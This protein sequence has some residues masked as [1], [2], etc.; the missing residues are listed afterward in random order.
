MPTSILGQFE[1]FAFSD[2][3]NEPFKNFDFTVRVGHR[4]H[5]VEDEL[6]RNEE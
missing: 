3:L 5:I 4:P 2:V 6:F 1:P